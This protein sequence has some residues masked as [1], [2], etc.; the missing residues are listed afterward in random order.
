MTLQMATPNVQS[1]SY[2]YENRLE[3]AEAELNTIP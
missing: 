1:V 2:N 3:N